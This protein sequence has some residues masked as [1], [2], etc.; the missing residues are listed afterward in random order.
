[1]ELQKAANTK[2]VLEN[3][4]IYLQHLE[5]QQAITILDSIDDPELKAKLYP[6]VFDGCCASEVIVPVGP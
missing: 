3:L 4:A 5:K 6:K 1:M 2:T